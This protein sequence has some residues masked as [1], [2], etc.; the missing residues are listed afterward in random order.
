[1]RSIIAAFVCCVV[2]VISATAT[3]QN[4]PDAFA[5]FTEFDRLASRSLWPGFDPGATPIAIYDGER[6]WLFRHPNPPDA[7]QEF[8][9]EEPVWYMDGW[10]THVR[11]NSNSEIGGVQTATLIARD[12]DPTDLAA[13][14]IHET[15]HVFQAEDHPDW[16]ANEV[17]LFVYPLE[18]AE[19]LLARRLETEALKRTLRAEDD[20]GRLCWASKAMSL[21]RGRF[22][23]MP[24]GS[25]EY[26]RGLELKEGLANYVEIK[27]AGQSG[28]DL[29]PSEGFGAAEVRER[30]YATGPAIAISLDRFDPGWQSRLEPETRPL[31]ELLFGALFERSPEPCEF[32]HAERRAAEE[33]A[34]ADVAA[35]VREREELKRDFLGQPGWKIVVSA[36][37]DAPLWPQN[38]DPLNVERVSTGEILHSR[39]LKLQGL[40]AGLEVLDRSALTVG[41]GAHPLF[42]GVLEV[43]ATG[44]QEEPLSRASGDTLYVD[45]PGFSGWFRGARLERTDETIVI[46][47]AP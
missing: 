41:A 17:E 9:E 29:F 24:E 1:M 32:N 43:V 22:A 38:F 33:R 11:S 42:D 10:H 31:D 26:E 23:L 18:Q 34:R 8:E 12:G 3:L 27:A 13:V 25:V 45:G 16:A 2:V 4:S 36:S 5:V 35:L 20:E 14:L 40:E 46:R 39:W 6:T 7:F 37:P 19:L 21:R 30:P 47:V 15:F 28:L 44:F